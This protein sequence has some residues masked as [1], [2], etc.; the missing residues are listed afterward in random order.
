[1]K[2]MWKLLTLYDKI[3]IV[4]LILLSTSFV[5]TPVGQFLIGNNND[6]ADRVILIQT[7][8]KEQERILLDSTYREE[9][10][11]IE[12]N[13]PLGISIIEAHNGKVRLKEAPPA[14]PEKTCEKTGWID[15]PGPIIIC[16][17]NQVSIWIE[18]ENFDLDGVSW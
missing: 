14:D 3:L 2:K 1:M 9:P 4:F 15:Q 8:N 16:V 11:F 5:L 7:A 17:P 10:F 6:N 13:G 12:V 18:V